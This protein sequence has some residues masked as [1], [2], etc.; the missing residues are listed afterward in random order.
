MK[1][2]KICSWLLVISIGLHPTVVLAVANDGK[3]QINNTINQPM[4]DHHT[5][6]QSGETDE[7]NG[8]FNERKVFDEKA[9]DH[10]RQQYLQQ[11]KNLAF[12]Q[13]KPVKD[14]LVSLLSVKK[15]IFNKPH[16]SSM[17]THS[18][19]EH[20]KSNH[21]VLIIVGVL[22]IIMIFSGLGYWLSSKR[23]VLLERSSHG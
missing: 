13:D 17:K 7:Q 16:Q 3:M 10:K 5:K 2:L 11:K 21:Q 18:L 12:R 6:D 22:L 15:V 1:W 23:K 14:H 8:L 19:A 9:L 20:Q 4:S